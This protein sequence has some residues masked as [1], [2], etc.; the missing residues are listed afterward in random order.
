MNYLAKKRFGQHFLQDDY[1]IHSIIKL[2]DPSPSE[3]LVEIGPGRGALTKPLCQLVEHL[4][5]IELDRDL[6]HF[7]QQTSYS[8]QLIIHHQNV[9]TFEFQ[10]LPAPYKIVGNLP[11]NISTPLL[12]YLLQY[13]KFIHST[14]FMLQKEV[15][16]RL[17]AKP[18]TSQ[19][20]K[21]SV[22]LQYHFDIEIL[23]NVPADAF[24]PKPKVES[25]VIRMIPR[26]PPLKAKN[27]QQFSRLITHAFQMKRKTIFNNLRSLVSKE[28]LLNLDIDPQQRPETISIEKYV[29]LSNSLS[30]R[31]KTS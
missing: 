25:A 8:Q 10:T 22:L 21:L 31:N 14:Y 18:G 3:T 1:L 9:L 13:E 2:I 7:L 16:L 4:H 15:A 17:T 28:E 23:L 27:W 24:V 19:F 26:P 11:Y 29:R 12:F 6:I 5:V 20:S 30:N